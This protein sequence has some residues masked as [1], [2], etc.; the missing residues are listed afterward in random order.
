MALGMYVQCSW[1]S[2]NIV[3]TFSHKLHPLGVMRNCCNWKIWRVELTGLHP[4]V[5][6]SWLTGGGGAGQCTRG[7]KQFGFH[8]PILLSPYIW[9]FYSRLLF[10][11]SFF[12]IYK[13]RPSQHRCTEQH[14]G[15]YSG[16]VCSETCLRGGAA[17]VYFAVSLSSWMWYTGIL[18][19]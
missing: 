13:T 11:M 5:P 2:E 14:W 8:V 4:W 12:S 10:L 19:V 3:R 9:C 6:S 7:L 1:L 18:C 15:F 17:A 16:G